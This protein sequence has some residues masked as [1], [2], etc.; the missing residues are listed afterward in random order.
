MAQEL[1]I[2]QKIIWHYL[3]GIRMDTTQNPS[4]P[5]FHLRIAAE[6]QET[7]PIFEAVSV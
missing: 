2:S 4:E 5:K 7:R 6:L 1:K 3:N